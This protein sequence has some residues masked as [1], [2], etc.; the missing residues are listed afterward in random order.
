MGELGELL[1]GAREARGISLEQAEAATRVRRQYLEALEAE[2][3]GRLPGEVYVRGFLRNYA[4]FLGLDPEEVLA[5]RGAPPEEAAPATFGAPLE[6]PLIR[7]ASR[8]I[9][10]RLLAVLLLLAVAVA[11]GWWVYQWYTGESPLSL[12][13]PA[14]T[15]TPTVSVTPTVP[16]TVPPTEAPTAT[17][18]TP[19]HTATSTPTQVP[20][21]TATPSL[22][23]TST[24]AGEVEVT[25]EVVELTWL[26]VTVDGELVLQ[27]SVEAGNRLSW[28]ALE[29]I[30]FRCG[31][32][33]G[34]IVTVDGEA[35][36]PLGDRGQVVDREWTAP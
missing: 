12:L 33:G 21:P 6:E 13:T 16:P 4:R 29:R 36:G 35:I 25:I 5:L 34:V 22:T 14:P 28:T 23:A 19:T 18:V 9:L 32:A 27:E 7:S 10:L 8:Q 26:E 2:D 24:P 30:A 31:N 20:P 15:S 3:F 1:R 11:A 17:V